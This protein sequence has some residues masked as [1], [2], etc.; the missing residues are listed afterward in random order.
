VR[1]DVLLQVDHVAPDFGSPGKGFSGQHERAVVTTS[2]VTDV[3]DGDST[4]TDV[5]FLLDMELW[6]VKACHEFR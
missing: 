4:G 1:E 2:S 6:N 3:L 5:V